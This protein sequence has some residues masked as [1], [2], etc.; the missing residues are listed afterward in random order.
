MPP[1]STKAHGIMDLAGGAALLGA[2]IALRDARARHVLR[3][4]GGS[5]LASGAVTDYELGLRRVLPMPVHLI[6]DAA[7]GALLLSSPFTL[8]RRR[9]SLASWLPHVVLGAGAIAGAALTERH[10]PEEEGAGAGAEAGVGTVT[11]R[12]PPAPAHPST[13]GPAARTAPGESGVQVAPAPVETPGPSVTPPLTPESDAERAEW[14]DSGRPDVDSP[15]THRE[16]DLLVA[17]EESAAAAEAAAIGGRVP[18]DA[19]D[20]AM[21]PVYQAGGGE[22]EGWEAAEADLIENA[23]HGDGRGNPLLD[24]PSPEA[25]SDLSTARYGEADELTASEVVE[26]PRE[27]GDDPGAGPGLAADR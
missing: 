3:A 10:P 7:V 26:D 1:I 16:E 22:Q 17:Q 11:S 8:R 21:D 27:R 15:Q 24:A 9:G 4:V 18:H 23:T 19:G 5:M 2:P 12:H 25:E 13:T 20:P 6:A 14:A